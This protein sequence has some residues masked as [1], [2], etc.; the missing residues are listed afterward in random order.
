MFISYFS[1]AIHELGENCIQNFHLGRYIVG[2]TVGNLVLRRSVI[3]P[4]IKVLN[5]V[6]PILMCFYCLISNW[7]IASRTKGVHHQMKCDAINDF[8]L[9]LTVYCRIY[10]RKYLTSNQTPRYKSKCIY[11]FAHSSHI[12]LKC[13]L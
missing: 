2:Y 9:F 1:I 4:K 6:I 7:S 13:L 8:K 11:I 12:I 5:K 10:C 3:P